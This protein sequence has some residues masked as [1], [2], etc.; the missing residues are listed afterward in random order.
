MENNPVWEFNGSYIR[1]KVDNIIVMLIDTDDDKL[2]FLDD[3]VM[4]I[5]MMKH[6]VLNYDEAKKTNTIE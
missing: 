1:I 2:Y 4:T 6:I 5:D 3:Y